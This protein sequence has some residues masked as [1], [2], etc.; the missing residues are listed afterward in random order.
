MAGWPAVGKSTL[1]KSV[2][3]ELP[4]ALHLEAESWI[5]PVAYRERRDLSG[6]NPLS[7]AT[8]DAIAQLRQL[9]QCEM[10]IELGQYCHGAGRIVSTRRLSAPR[11]TPYVLDGTLFSVA[12]FAEFA[13]LR[14]FIYPADHQE[15]LEIASQRDVNE[16]GFPSTAARRK[17]VAKRD[18]MLR[19]QDQ[20]TGARFIEWSVGTGTG[21]EYLLEEPGVA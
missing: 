10:P 9:L 8:T 20:A 15:W 5:Y 3:E 14:F 1:A 17:N 19:L 11:S 12:D 18:D 13:D 4:T 16:R 7:Y 21:F 2:V 6:S